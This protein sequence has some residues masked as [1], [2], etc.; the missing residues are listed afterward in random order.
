MATQSRSI[1]RKARHG[2]IR[3]R[4]AGTTER[5]RLA[6]F[7]S[8]KHISA[9]IIDDVNGVTLAAASTMEKSLKATDTVDGARKVG[10]EL[11]KRAQDKGVKAVVFDRGGFQYH[12]VVAG[13][14][15]GARKGGL[16]F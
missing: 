15:E 4:L 16:E 11:A 14:A 7:K 8:Q 12:G 13:L 10:E 2:R 9:Q 6:V 5:P 1:M 3:K